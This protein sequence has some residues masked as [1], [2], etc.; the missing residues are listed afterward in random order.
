MIRT[1]AAVLRFY[2]TLRRL[3]LDV[4]VDV[5]G[6]RDVVAVVVR[7]LPSTVRKSDRAAREALRATLLDGIAAW[8][9]VEIAE[10]KFAPRRK[11]RRYPRPKDEPPPPRARRDAPPTQAEDLRALGLDAMPDAAGLK[12][13]WRAAAKRHHP[14]AGGDAE[15]FKRAGAAY[16]RLAKAMRR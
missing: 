4:D 5:L 14:D 12:R 2:A 11:V 15:A 16:E 13:A 8:C 7:D 1:S 6:R 9:G 3:R 10:K